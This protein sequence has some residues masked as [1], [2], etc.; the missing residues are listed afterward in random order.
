MVAEYLVPF[1]NVKGEALIYRGKWD[2]VDEK[3]LK[4][5]Q[6]ELEKN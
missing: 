2:L 5:V 4:E 1:I 3:K 6:I